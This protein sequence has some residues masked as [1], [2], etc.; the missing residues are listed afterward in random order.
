ML[1]RSEHSLFAEQTALKPGLLQGLDPRVKI[2]GLVALIIDVT[3][4][5]N[6]FTIVLA[7]AVGIGL[8]IASRAPIAAV[9]KRGWLPALL[10]TGV[11]AIPVIFVTPGETITRIPLLN[12]GVTQQGVT[13][14]LYLISRVEATATLS[15]LL[16]L[17]TRWTHI[18]KGLRVLYVPVVFVVILGMTYRYIFV[19]LESARNMLIARR[20]RFVGK[21]DGRESRRFAA[22]NIGVLLAKSLQLN[23]DVYLAMQ[24]RGFRGE[25]YVIDDFL[26]KRRDWLALSLFTFTAAVV[27]WLGRQDSLLSLLRWQS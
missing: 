14:A 16:V 22:G 24:S 26:M 6:L 13:S 19:M 20:S 3:L 5:R 11:I 1:R 10:F 27:F 9:A 7:F 8:A 23:T 4:S 17:C 2:I 25:V 21:M 12:L 18:L 15:I